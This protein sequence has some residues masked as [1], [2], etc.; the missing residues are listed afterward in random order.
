[1][2]ISIDKG[3]FVYVPVPSGYFAEVLTFLNQLLA[4]SSAAEPGRPG[5]ED[6]A[7]DD[8]EFWT[9]E[10]L[11]LL[12]SQLRYQ[13]ARQALD[14]AARESPRPVPMTQVERETP[15]RTAREIAADLGALTKL[16]R[17]LF[18]RK[19]WPMRAVEMWAKDENK[20][21]M[22]YVMSSDVAKRW[23]SLS[24]TPADKNVEK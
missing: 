7:S 3:Q 14:L 8:S 12:Q 17:K 5:E 6:L 22:H 19:S 20:W 2:E 23:N 13:G 1:V 21:C 9:Y 15:S 11:S 10:R 16:C 18:G 24:E 4:A